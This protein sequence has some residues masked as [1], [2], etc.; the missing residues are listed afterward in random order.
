M[1]PRSSRAYDALLPRVITFAKR[2]SIEI[3]LDGYF[4]STAYRGIMQFQKFTLISLAVARLAINDTYACNIRLAYLST[5][6][7]T[8]RIIEKQSS[9]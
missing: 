7:R 1:Q 8:V 2:V 6:F 3:R 5:Q 9:F 4:R